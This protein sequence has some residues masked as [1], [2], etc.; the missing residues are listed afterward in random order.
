MKIKMSHPSR[1]VAKKRASGR[2]GPIN[3][4]LDIKLWIKMT[5]ATLTR[6]GAAPCQAILRT[7][8]QMQRSSFVGKAIVAP[9]KV[10][11]TPLLRLSPA[12][13]ARM[14]SRRAP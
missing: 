2:P 9:L 8:A 4:G 5:M 3:R 12:R 14:L 7:G 6:M 13:S 10:G 11:S 1:G